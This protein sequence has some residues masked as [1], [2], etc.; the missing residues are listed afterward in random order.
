MGIRYTQA[1]F[2][3]SLLGASGASYATELLCKGRGWLKVGDGFDATALVKLDQKTLRAS[4]N[5]WVGTAKG[6]LTADEKIYKGMLTLESGEQ[7]WINLDRYTGEL[8][9]APPTTEQNK[10]V[11]FN[12]VCEA[13]KPKF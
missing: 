1:V 5:L 12:G 3:V 2:F 11:L 13:A 9:V 4:L 6:V 10:P 7:I 8:L